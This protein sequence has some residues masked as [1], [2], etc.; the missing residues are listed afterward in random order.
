MNM[1]KDRQPYAPPRAEVEDVVEIRPRP[2]TG[3][4]VG[5][6]VD[7]GGTVIAAVILA[8]AY[9]AYLTSQGVD[10]QAIQEALATAPVGSAYFN[11]AAAV[12]LLFSVLGGYVCAAY[13]RRNLYRT[14]LVL[15]AIVSAVGFLVGGTTHSEL[16][17]VTIVAANS[18]A[19][20]FGAWWYRRKH[21]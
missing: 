11:I 7:L 21:A 1:K 18:A 4:V 10:P 2:I 20:L 17:N 9:S 15:A 16:Y 8:I 12:G 5:A 14:G 6:V 19:V 3:V 13:A